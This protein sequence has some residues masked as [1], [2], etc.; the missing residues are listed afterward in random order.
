M[1]TTGHTQC[2]VT[3]G[4][5]WAMTYGYPAAAASGGPRYPTSRIPA[6]RAGSSARRGTPSRPLRRSTCPRPVAPHAQPPAA[7]P[8]SPQ[9]YPYSPQPYSAPPTSPP[10]PYRGS[11]QAV[12]TAVGAAVRRAHHQP[13]L[14]AG[15]RGAAA[16]T[17]RPAS[18]RRR[19]REPAPAAAEQPGGPAQGLPQL[20]AAGAHLPDAA[21]AAAGA[22]GTGPDHDRSPADGAEQPAAGGPAGH[23]SSRRPGPGAAPPRGPIRPALPATRRPRGVPF[24][25]VPGLIRQLPHH[26]PWMVAIGV[27]AIAVVLSVCGL[28][29]YLLVKDDSAIVGAAPTPESTV[30]KRDISNRDADP[31]PL[32]AADVVPRRPTSWWTRT[33]RRTSGSA[34]PQVAEDCRVGANGEVGTLLKD[35]GLQPGRPGHVPH[36]RRRAPASPPASSTCPT[37][38]RPQRRHRRHRQDPRARSRAFAGPAP[39]REDAGAGP[40]GHQVRAGS[41]RATSCSTSSS[42]GLDGSAVRG[43]TIPTAKVIVYDMVEK[44]L[45]DHV[46]RR[47]VDRQGRPLPATAASANSRVQARRLRVSSAR[48]GVLGRVV[49]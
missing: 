38:P 48:R 43:S 26:K 37:R 18:T 7:Q 31:N 44:Y 15:P 3:F 30:L 27:I 22:T 19:H 41:A 21:D 11:P 4:S 47:L 2:G 45:R 39:I 9:P 34:T 36:A 46:M 6:G 28:G 32:T 12:P 23:T 10:S 5:L 8:H 24:Q 42:S 25:E 1:R 17:R 49:G 40:Q 29:S 35:N 13:A 33:F 16:P 20:P 14:P